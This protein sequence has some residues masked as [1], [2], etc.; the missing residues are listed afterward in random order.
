MLQ[1]QPE[2]AVPR[3][4]PITHREGSAT[5]APALQ[6]RASESAAPWTGRLM[7]CVAPI[8]GH[9]L[10]KGVL[11]GPLWCCDRS[12]ALHVFLISLYLQSRRLLDQ[13]CVQGSAACGD[14]ANRVLRVLRQRKPG[15]R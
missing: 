12:A 6:V 1:N 4:Q 13:L 15:R 8:T 5:L 7:G 2:T 9:K 14:W 10:G 3:L 11:R